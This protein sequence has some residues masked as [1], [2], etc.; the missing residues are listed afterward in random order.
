MVRSLTP[1]PLTE[2]YSRHTFDRTRPSRRACSSSWAY[3]PAFRLAEHAIRVT[4]T[5]AAS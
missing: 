5:G 1:A 2:P 4:V 3:F